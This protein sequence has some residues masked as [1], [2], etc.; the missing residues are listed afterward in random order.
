M[1]RPKSL[2]G[3]IMMIVV[4]CILMLLIGI[5]AGLQYLM[6]RYSGSLYDQAKVALNGIA[7]QV[8]NAFSTISL[9]IRELCVDE[10]LQESIRQWEAR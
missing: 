7:A 5:G 8:E 6:P 3:R 2:A 1:L 9:D 10:R 4:I